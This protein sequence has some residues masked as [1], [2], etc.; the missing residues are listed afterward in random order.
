[1]V[2]Q[3]M[4][5]SNVATEF[6]VAGLS[7]QASQIFNNGWLI[8]DKIFFFRSYLKRCLVFLAWRLYALNMLSDI[9]FKIV[10]NDIADLL[11]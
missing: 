2:M 8:A 6:S 3:W 11:M 9:Y 1:M 4:K 7:L 10:R 5:K